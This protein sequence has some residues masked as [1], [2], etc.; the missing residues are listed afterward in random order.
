MRRPWRVGSVHRVEEPENQAE[1]DVGED[2]GERRAHAVVQSHEARRISA[3]G[4]RSG[5]T[6]LGRHPRVDAGHVGYDH[7]QH[8]RRVAWCGSVPGGR[9]TALR[10]GA[11]NPQVSLK[12]KSDS[13]NKPDLP[14]A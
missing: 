13:D 6:P 14:L 8:E 3:T 11:A 10:G 4:P 12:P 7:R 5:R 9:R 1:E 2:D